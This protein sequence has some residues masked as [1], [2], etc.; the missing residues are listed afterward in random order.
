MPAMRSPMAPTCSTKPRDPEAPVR[1]IL[2]EHR[3]RRSLD[4]RDETDRDHPGLRARQP[5]TSGPDHRSDDLDELEPGLPSEGFDLQVQSDRVDE[6]DERRLAVALDPA[7]APGEQLADT[8]A[9][10]RLDLQCAELDHERVAEA[11]EALQQDLLLRREVVVHRGRC[12]V[13][14]RRDV[15]DRHLVDRDGGEQTHRT[16]DD[17]GAPRRT[18]GWTPGVGWSID[19]STVGPVAPRTTK[20]AA[21]RSVKRVS[22]VTAQPAHRP[23]RRGDIVDAA[24]RLFARKGFVDAAISDVAEEADV[25]VTAVYY[26]FSGKEELFTAAVHKVF[27]SISDVVSSVRSDDRPERRGVAR[28]GHRCGVG[29]DRHPSGRGDARPPPAAGRDPPDLDP[30]PRVRGSPRAPGVRLP[31]RRPTG[32]PVRLRAGRSRT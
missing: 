23:S 31:R 11:L 22:R 25:V 28:P 5:P 9:L 32:S 16:V 21:P 10:A 8:V 18:V 1:R 12:H 19:T 24:I 17:V 7:R 29:L 14:R 27:D 15:E 3:G 2:V 6:V 4:Q 13:D 30:A 26:H 20:S